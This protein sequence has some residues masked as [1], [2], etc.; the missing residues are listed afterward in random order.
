MENQIR[1]QRKEEDLY[2]I[3]IADDGTAIV[4]D[5]ADIALPIKCDEAFK[6]VESNKNRALSKVKMVEN[7]YKNQKMNPTL[8]RQKS[9]EVYKAINE[10][11]IENREIMDNLMGLP[12][13]MQKLFG[14]SNYLDMYQ[15]LYEQLEPHFKKMN[16]NVNRIKQR[17]ENKYGSKENV[18]K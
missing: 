17:I 3:E 10:M 2:K 18:I 7:K 8:E 1:I 9:I 6:K 13:A 5:L 16:L 15:D 11:Y 4:F 12:G 14:D